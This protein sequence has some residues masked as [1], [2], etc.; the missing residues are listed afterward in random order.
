VLTGASSSWQ[1]KAPSPPDKKKSSRISTPE[2]AME[3]EGTLS[4]A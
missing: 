1:G 3:R 2:Q 4:F